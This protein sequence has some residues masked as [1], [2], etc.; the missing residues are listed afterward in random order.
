MKRW[1]CV[2]LFFGGVIALIVI[3]NRDVTAGPTTRP[4]TDKRPVHKVKTVGQFVQAIGPNR[5]IELAPG[6]YP[7]SKAVR[8]K[9][10]HVR[11]KK[12]IRDEYDLIVV[13][14]PNLAIRGVGPKA[15]HL[16]VNAAY[17]HV[18]NFEKCPGLELADLKMGHHPYPGYCTGG[19]VRIEEAD[20]VL[21]R[22]CI[23]YGCGTEGLRL[24]KVK[25]F[26]CVDS[27]I[28]KCTYGIL[29]ADDA[30]NL[31]F[32]RSV[33][34]ANSK[35]YG[36]NFRDS[37]AV[38]FRDCTV[39]D[40]VLGG[41][42]EP[43]FETNLNS[44]TA[45]ITFV[46]GTIEGNA[47]TALAKPPAMVTFRNA[48]IKGNSWQAPAAVKAKRGKKIVAAKGGWHYHVP[49]GEVEFWDISIGA[50]GRGWYSQALAKANPNVTEPIK[51]DTRIYCPPT[52]PKNVYPKS[53]QP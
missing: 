1:S 52:P 2:F 34:R 4:A 38:S 49:V 9:L 29:T 33:F 40:N 12:A 21:I 13:D 30:E 53:P 20:G 43:L 6:T 37:I 41:L 19:V 26:L 51:P 46:G 22:K 31:R 32:E 11:W 5:I 10:K 36:F 15:V 24:E 28:E 18:L 3:G 47:A 45:R 39:T 25:N 14:A 27:V 8:R 35:F 23:L 44:D 50:Y 7:L 17:A 16:A 42:K 48:K